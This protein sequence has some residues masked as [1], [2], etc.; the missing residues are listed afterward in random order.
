MKASP[1][2]CLYTNRLPYASLIPAT[3]LPATRSTARS[4]LGAGLTLVV[5]AC[6][7]PVYERSAGQ[8]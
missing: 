2:G 6:Y 5:S 7:E 1:F 3:I 4:P 8:T